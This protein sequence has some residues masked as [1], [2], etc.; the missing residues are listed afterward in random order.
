M[1]RQPFIFVS[2]LHGRVNLYRKLFSLVQR[3]LPQAV[4]L[5][6]DLLPSGSLRF[7]SGSSGHDNFPDD[8]LVPELGNLR[9]TLDKN[10]PRFF[11]I[12]GNDDARSEEGAFLRADKDALW[13]YM[14]M[15]KKVHATFSIYGYS[16]VP[17]TPFALKDW[18]RYDISRFVDPGSIPPEEGRFT[19][20][21]PE[22]KFAI[23]TI[24]E[25]L[26]KLAGQEALASA[27]FL[28]HS[29][30]YQTH[31]DRAALDGRQVDHAPLDV[32]VGSI[33]IK[34]F[35]EDRQPLITLHG[36]VHESARLTG[37]WQE[38]IGRTFC[39]SA[40]HDGPELAVVCFDPRDPGSAVRRL[41]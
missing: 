10:Y 16:C 27:I 29:P 19:V 20:P 7:G 34:R 18:E 25:D 32:H 37:S 21:L 23:P 13:Q 2:D 40:A 36:H 6:G 17:P 11:L 12:L 35:I 4:F 3:D 38:K 39:F 8:F 33:A 5:G 1:P 26:E 9:R 30:P 22:N 24:R 15:R 31:L 28:F 14:H 41:V